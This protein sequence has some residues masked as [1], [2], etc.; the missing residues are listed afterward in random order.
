MEQN[1][2]LYTLLVKLFRNIMNIEEEVLISGEF[3]DITIN[4]IHVIEAIGEGEPKP[5]SIVA[6]KLSVT[7]GTLTKSID[8]LTRNKYVL[9]E[10]SEEDKRLVLLSLTEKGIRA[11]VHHKRFH[12]EMVESALAQF[13]EQETRILLK[14]LSG[15][16]D[17]FIEQKNNSMDR[18]ETDNQEGIENTETF[19]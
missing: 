13:D 10:R 12:K 5:S 16:V 19:C 6:K 9:R 18:K 17:F 7:M 14:S 2:T 4:D 3:S 8:R 1:K 15:L 11:D